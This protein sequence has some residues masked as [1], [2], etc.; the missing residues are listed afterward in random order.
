MKSYY[1][2]SGITRL[3]LV[4]PTVVI[5]FPNFRNKYQHFLMGLVA[6]IEEKQ[7]WQTSKILKTSHLLAPVLWASWG[8]WFLIMK[9]AETIPV[10]VYDDTEHR[11]YYQGDD[12]PENYG[13]ID[14]KLVKIDYGQTSYPE[15]IS[16]LRR[17]ISMDN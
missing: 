4:L 8:G 13:I 2:T 1:F 15:V 10:A 12:K 16:S 9:R 3:V 7:T 17:W 6:N 5:K 11:R 14:G